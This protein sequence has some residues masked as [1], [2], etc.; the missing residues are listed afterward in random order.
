LW[1]THEAFSTRIAEGCLLK[2]EWIEHFR[3]IYFGFD[4]DH[5]CAKRAVLLAGC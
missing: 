3:V 2:S 4:L 1:T 5:A